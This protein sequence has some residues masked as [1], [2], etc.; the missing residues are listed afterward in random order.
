M[1][2]H[3]GLLALAI[4]QQSRAHKAIYSLPLFGSSGKRSL[5]PFQAAAETGDVKVAEILSMILPQKDLSAGQP[6]PPVHRDPRK[7]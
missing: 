2:C 3:Y 4:D 7:P 6:S 5:L 1:N